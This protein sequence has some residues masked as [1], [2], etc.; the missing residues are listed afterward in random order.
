MEAWILKSYYFGSYVRQIWNNNHEWKIVFFI[1]ISIYLVGMI[2]LWQRPTLYG[3]MLTNEWNSVS[4]E[5]INTHNDYYCDIE[6][7]KIISEVFQTF[8]S[9]DLVRLD[10]F[11]EHRI[12][13]ISNVAKLPPWWMVAPSTAKHKLGSGNKKN[14]RLFWTQVRSMINIQRKSHS[15]T[16][17]PHRYGESQAKKGGQRLHDTA[18][19]YKLHYLHLL[20]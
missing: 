4:T 12:F 15:N 18:S 10:K 2:S 5:T 17:F 7:N 16:W 13:S 8:F 1:W 14:C 19:S 20:Q 3:K 11:G 9:L 6:C